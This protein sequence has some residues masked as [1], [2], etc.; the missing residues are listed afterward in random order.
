MP[1]YFFNFESDGTAKAD[2][3]GRD[4]PDDHAAK[5][6]GA[7]L[8]A[9]MGMSA[10][11]EGKWPAYEWVEIVDDEERAVARLPVSNVIREPNRS[12]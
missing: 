2:L 3:V 7:K 8:A 1:R 9:D 4:F 6:E 12:F 5:V 11:L 10:A